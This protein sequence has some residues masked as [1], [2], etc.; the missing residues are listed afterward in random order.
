MQPSRK[1]DS[2][3]S[4]TLFK[5]YINERKEYEVYDEDLLTNCR[6]NLTKPNSTKENIIKEKTN[7]VNSKKVSGGLNPQ[8]TQ[9]SHLIGVQKTESEKAQMKERMGRYAERYQQLL[10]KH[11]IKY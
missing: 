10:D 2:I 8:D 11:D 9:G 3:Y 5:L 7:E 4:E 6:P 1:V